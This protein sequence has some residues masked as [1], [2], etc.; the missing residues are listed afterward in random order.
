MCK[1]NKTNKTNK[2]NKVRE[3]VDQTSSNQGKLS[4]VVQKEEERVEL[5]EEEEIELK[6][7]YSRV[8]CIIITILENDDE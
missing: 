5:E 6:P 7:L 2:D 3:E 1:T 8:G 4:W